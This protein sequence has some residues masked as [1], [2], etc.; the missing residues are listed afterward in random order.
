MAKH[1]NN[2]VVGGAA[3]LILGIA[4]IVTSLFH[5]GEPVCDN[6]TMHPG[7]VCIVGGKAIG[8]ESRKA[9]NAQTGWLQLGLG[10]GALVV[11]GVLIGLY[12]RD[13]RRAAALPPAA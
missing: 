13:R 1:A 5:H 11:G 7:D 6:Q 3:L 12:L 4:L 8:Y 2:K 9:D 10:G